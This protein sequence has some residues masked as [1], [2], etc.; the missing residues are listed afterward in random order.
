M[1]YH[2]SKTVKIKGFHLAKITLFGL[3]ELK[4]CLPNINVYIFVH[5]FRYL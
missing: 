1:G 2:R 4:Y 3:N 5:D